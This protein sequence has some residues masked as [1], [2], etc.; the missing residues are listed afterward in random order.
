M[1]IE[2]Q[3]KEGTEKALTP[4]RQFITDALAKI[5]G[6]TALKAS[7]TELTDKLT[8]AEATIA[9]QAS[10]I[11]KLTADHAAAVEA[12]TAEVQ[13]LTAEHAT[14]LETARKTAGASTLA[15]VGVVPVSETATDSHQGTETLETIRAQIAAEKD[16]SKRYALAAK[17]RELRGHADIFKRN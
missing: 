7:V 5:N 2:T 13:R 11:T 8:K 17:A 10:Q 4:F 3:A 6:D 12:H 15:K 14:A 16:P 1:D 9:E